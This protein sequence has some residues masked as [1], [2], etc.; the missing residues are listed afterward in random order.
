MK[1]SELIEQL[2]GAKGCFG[3]CEVVARIADLPNV[4]FPIVAFRISYDT[5]AIVI[6]IRTSALR[7]R[8]LCRGSKR[9][10]PTPR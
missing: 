7:G 3:D 1:V 8:T 2:D 4:D 6:P 5:G 10:P 9:W